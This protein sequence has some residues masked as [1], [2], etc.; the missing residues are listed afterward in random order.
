M[1]LGGAW[2]NYTDRISSLEEQNRLLIE[3]ITLTEED[4]DALRLDRDEVMERFHSSVASLTEQSSTHMQSIQIIEAIRVEKNAYFEQSK[5][6]DA[7]CTELTRALH[8]AQ[9]E[10]AVLKVSNNGLKAESLSNAALLEE[11]RN[12]SKRLRDMVYK[13][14]EQIDDMRKQI[15]ERDENIE[16]MKHSIAGKDRQLMMLIKERDK[17]KDS[18]ELLRRQPPVFRKVSAEDHTAAMT[19]SNATRTEAPRAGSYSQAALTKEFKVSFAKQ[20]VVDSCV[21]AANAAQQSFSRA[22]ET[23]ERQYKAIIRKLRAELDAANA[24]TRSTS[25]PR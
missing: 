16:S 7:L 20:P 12:E 9:D 4:R 1:K 19:S 5:K 25:L 14:D 3:R 2:K 10:V 22:L 17:I 24:R 15:S 13:R 21:D 6:L 11:E 8:R 23:S 18:L